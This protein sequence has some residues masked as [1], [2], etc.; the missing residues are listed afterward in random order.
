MRGFFYAHKILIYKR[1]ITIYERLF[2][3]RIY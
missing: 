3:R 2:N 1:N